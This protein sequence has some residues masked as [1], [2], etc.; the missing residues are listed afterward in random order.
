LPGQHSSQVAHPA[1]LYVPAAQSSHVDAATAL[2]T[3]DAMPA[4]HGEGVLVPF[5]GHQYPAG[6]GEQLEE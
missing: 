2:V 1:Q 4:G 6:Q 5:V 3:L